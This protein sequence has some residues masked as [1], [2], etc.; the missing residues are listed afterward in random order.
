MVVAVTTRSKLRSV[1]FFPAML[2][3]TI[4][5][6]RQLARTRGIVRWASVVASPTEFWTLTVWTSV[7]ELQE[8]MRSGAHGEVMWQMPRWLRSFWL[9]RWRP[10]GAEVGAWDG[11]ELADTGV[12]ATVA[13]PAAVAESA[14]FVLR[15]LETGTLTYAQSALVRR[16]RA[17]LAGVG[18]IAVRIA[19]S[20]ISL[21]SALRDLRRLRRV[22]LRRSRGRP[23]LR[24][25]RAL[26]RG[27]PLR[28]LAG[29]RLA[30][31]RARRR[32]DAPCPGTVG[33]TAL[34]A[35][36]AARARVRPL[37]RDAH[38]RAPPAPRSF[39]CRS[40]GY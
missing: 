37:G 15:A 13:P 21:P 23:A 17:Q 4:R 20:P 6:R 12:G 25:R 18:G 36:V 10:G 30:A 35:R 28:A 7:H 11:L 40:V 26:Q 34:G 16:S 3:A 27:V 32:V 22:A 39:A 8:F 19:A 33:R 24:R 1:R 29:C 14:E 2:V 5:A 38:A 9:A 31:R